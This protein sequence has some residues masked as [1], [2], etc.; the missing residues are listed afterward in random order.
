MILNLSGTMQL[1]PR[2]INN[3][4]DFLKVSTIKKMDANVP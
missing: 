1:Y 4:C 2:V 3:P